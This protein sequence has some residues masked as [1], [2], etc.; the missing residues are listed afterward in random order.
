MIDAP[1]IMCVRAPEQP[2][3]DEWL[4]QSIGYTRLMDLPIALVVAA[5]LVGV[6]CLFLI[7]TR[8]R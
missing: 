2:L 7:L 5:T 1:T 8:R 4:S 3:Q 6:T